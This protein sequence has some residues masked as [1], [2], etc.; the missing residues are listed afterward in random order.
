MSTIFELGE[1]QSLSLA[2]AGLKPVEAAIIGSG[3]DAAVM[4][5]DDG[6]YLVS[7]DT[8]I[9]GND[10]KFEFSTAFDLGWKAIA[11]NYADIAAMGGAP[12]GSVVALCVPAKTEIEWLKQFVD[13]LQQA[14][15]HFAPGSG[16]VGGDL[17]TGDHAFISVTVFGNL[18][19]NSA[20]VRSGAKIG[21]GVY[22]GGTL[23][24]AACGLDLLNHPDQQFAK[25]YNQFV[26][27]QLRPNPPI[28]LGMQ[29]NLAGATAM[30]DISDG[31]SSDAT[32]LAQASDLSIDIDSSKLIG[33]EAVLEQAAQSIS[34]DAR[35]W[36]L[37]G[38]ED[39]SLLATFSE[40]AEVPRG[41]KKI[42]ICKKADSAL[43]LD[44][45][46]IEPKGWDSV[47]VD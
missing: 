34:A 4:F 41:F 43:T 8:M 28:A 46:P 14:A 40:G 25:S 20:V 27:I 2:L 32:R 35:P 30:M 11:T 3:D 10:F 45:K 15:D 37:H 22:V 17:A 7:T 12:T 1:K 42:G 36:V 38:G 13:G 47:K 29:A 9:E 6:N 18:S 31:L 33:Y 19:G 44:G 26:D 16:I 21:D 39:H 23:G 5:S 24:H